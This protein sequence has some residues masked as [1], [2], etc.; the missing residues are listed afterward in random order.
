M[1]LPSVIPLSWKICAGAALVGALAVGHAIRVRHAYNAGHDAAV[2]ERAGRDLVA[3]VGRV[4]E[5]AALEARHETINLTITKAKDEELA[6]VRERIVTRRVY[7]G[8]AIC[9]GPAAPAKTEDATGGD[10]ADPAGRLLPPEMER[11]I[12]ALILETEEAA[13]TGRACQAWG[14]EEGYVP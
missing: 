9:N 11:D 14:K 3:V 1:K 10:G 7:V 6:P 13:A 2:A 8:P 4:Q 12:K 5:N